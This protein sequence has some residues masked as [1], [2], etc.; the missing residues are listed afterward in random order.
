MTVVPERKA[1]AIGPVSDKP[2]FL[3]PVERTENFHA[4]KAG[5]LIHQVR[6][7]TE[8]LFDLRGLVV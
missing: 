4:Y 7:M 3:G 8:G 5:P 1:L 6:T 2:D